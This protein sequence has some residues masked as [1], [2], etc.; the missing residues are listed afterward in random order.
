MKPENNRNSVVAGLVLH[1]LDMQSASD[2]F[3]V[4]SVRIRQIVHRFCN[5]LDRRLYTEGCSV[6]K[7]EYLHTPSIEWLRDHFKH[8]VTH[9]VL[10]SGETK[11]ANNALRG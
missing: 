1:G 8:R 7:Y 4:S 10:R 6:D 9:V 3:N 5:K 2:T 11:I